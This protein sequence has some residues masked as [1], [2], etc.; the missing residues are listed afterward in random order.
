[1]SNSC[2]IEVKPEL[3]EGTVVEITAGS[4]RGIEGIVESRKNHSFLVVNIDM[5]GHSVRA[6]IKAENLET[7]L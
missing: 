4:F 5:L 2:Q 6:E 3:I 7:T 1:M